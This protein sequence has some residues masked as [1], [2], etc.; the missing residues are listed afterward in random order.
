MTLGVAGAVSRELVW[1]VA[2]AAL[3]DAAAL[4]RVEAAGLSPLV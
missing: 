1:L 3:L 2:W 4:A